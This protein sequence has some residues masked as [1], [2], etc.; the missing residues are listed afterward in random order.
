MKRLAAA[1]LLVLSGLFCLA[2]PAAAGGWA[3]TTLDPLPDL[4][5]DETVTIGF[6]IRQHGVTP[7]DLDGVSIVVQPAAGPETSFPARLAGPKGHY[8]AEIQVP[9]GTHRW[10]VIQGPF[11]PQDLGTLTTSSASTSA[12]PVRDPGSGWPLWGLLAAT[13]AAVGAVAAATTFIAWPA[14]RARARRADVMA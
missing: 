8:V 3:E 7:V 12:D 11:G 4:P 2:T 14:A 9:A 13:I 5:P 1:F 6:T 10:R